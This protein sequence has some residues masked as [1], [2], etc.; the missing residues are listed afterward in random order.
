MKRFCYRC[1]G[2]LFVLFT[3]E[4]AGVSGKDARGEPVFRAASAIEC[5]GCGGAVEYLGRVSG[6]AL[7]TDHVQCACDGRCTSATGPKCSCKCEGDNHG[8]GAVVK[9]VRYE[10]AVPK[11]S[12]LDPAGQKAA[13]A[14]FAGAVEAAKARMV[15]FYGGYLEDYRTGVRIGSYETWSGIRDAYGAIAKAK[16]L[17]SRGGRLKALGRVCPEPDPDEDVSR[18]VGVYE[19]CPERGLKDARTFP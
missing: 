12:A 6:D 15:A 9:V 8:S 7:Y 3:E 17:K 10:G 18:V 4:R 16:G 13:A 2:C 5:E 11:L 1:K 14:E 19:G